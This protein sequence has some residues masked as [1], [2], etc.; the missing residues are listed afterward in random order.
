LSSSTRSKRFRTFRLAVMV[1]APFRLRC[2]DINSPG[3]LG[4]IERQRYDATRHFQLDIR[5]GAK[6]SIFV[7]A[8]P[9]RAGFYC[10]PPFQTN[11]C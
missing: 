7:I 6:R 11:D 1:L 9:G 3:L 10:S 4:G 5:S 8:I 2:C